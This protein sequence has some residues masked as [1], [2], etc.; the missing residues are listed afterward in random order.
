MK[1]SFKKKSVASFAVALHFFLIIA[2]VTHVETYFGKHTVLLPFRWLVDYYSAVTFANRNFGFFAPKV[3]ADWNLR[4]TITGRDGASRPYN[5]RIPNNEMQVRMYSM[6][7]HFGQSDAHMDLFARSWGVKAM[8]E[9]AGVERVDVEVTQN[10]IP[11]MKEY[12]EGLRIHP[13][14]LYSTTLE[15]R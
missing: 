13:E 10:Q 5:F 15:L 6:M 1:I 11:T 7:G 2:V 14:F 8:N 3:T 4:M 9:N 12:R